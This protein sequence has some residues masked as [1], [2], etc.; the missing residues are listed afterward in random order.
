MLYYLNLKKNDLFYGLSSV[1]F[2]YNPVL[3]RL[4]AFKRFIAYCIRGCY[5]TNCLSNYL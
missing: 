3:S 5:I 4:Q 2:T 1:L